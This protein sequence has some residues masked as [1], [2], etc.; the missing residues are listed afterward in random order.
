MQEITIKPEA[1]KLRVEYNDYAV[2][3]VMEDG[4]FAT[5]S[6]NYLISDTRENIRAYL[7]FRGI[8]VTV[9]DNFSS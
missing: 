8:D 7:C 1:K 5:A 4:E 3:S 6:G 9:L 2:L